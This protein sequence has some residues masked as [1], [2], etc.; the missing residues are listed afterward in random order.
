MGSGSR[1]ATQERV[2]SGTYTPLAGS[3]ELEGFN[4]DDKLLSAPI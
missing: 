2:T 3:D 1:V 4:F